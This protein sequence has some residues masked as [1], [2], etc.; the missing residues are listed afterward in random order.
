M[1]RQDLRVKTA[2]KQEEK[3]KEKKTLPETG[4]YV[5]EIRE[6]IPRANTQFTLSSEVHEEAAASERAPWPYYLKCSAGLRRASRESRKKLKKKKED[7]ARKI[8]GYNERE[9]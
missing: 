5:K 6:I 2:S 7:E 8:R 1:S 3:K 4:R 9:T